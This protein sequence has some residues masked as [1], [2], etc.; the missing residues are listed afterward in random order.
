MTERLTANYYIP[1]AYQNAGDGM[2][3]LFDLST[4]HAGLVEQLKE[5]LKYDI[6]KIPTTKII[7]CEHIIKYSLQC[8]MDDFLIFNDAFEWLI[9]DYIE[10]D[11]NFLGG[12]N[13]IK[14]RKCYVH[15]SRIYNELIDIPS[16]YKEVMEEDVTNWECDLAL[17]HRE[18]MCIEDFVMKCISMKLFDNYTDTQMN[19]ADALTNLDYFGI[20]VNP[21][22]S[23]L[24]SC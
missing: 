18:G 23:N 4:R 15:E 19:L 2:L 9:D 16:I 10:L 11:N 20:K 24:V 17:N 5:R 8:N 21:E 3:N 22:L 12:K 6:N 14:D 13:P 7:N 1:I